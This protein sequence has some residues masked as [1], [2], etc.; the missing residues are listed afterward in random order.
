MD[1]GTEFQL[2]LLPTGSILNA[3]NMLAERKH[4]VN[5]R[6]T[7]N[8][9][10]YYLK[11]NR[12][13]ETAKQYPDFAKRLLQQRGKAFADKSREQNPMDFIRGNPTFFDA[14]DR[15]LDPE[16][17]KRLINVMFH[18]KNA[19]VYYVQ[20]NRKDRKVKN[21]RQILEEFIKKKKHQKEMKRQKKRELDAMTLEEKLEKLIDDD[22]VLTEIQFENVQEKLNTIVKED[23]EQ[24]FTQLRLL[25]SNFMDRLLKRDSGKSALNEYQKI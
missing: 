19:V 24:N 25:K 22:K 11:Y 17:S 7:M 10:F 5:A 13:V 14:H 1:A 23:I 2:E 15:P 8:T 9:T 4:A 3:H 20:K 18:L 21:L 6:F 16:L 12:L